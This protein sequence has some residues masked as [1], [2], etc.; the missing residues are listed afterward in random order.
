MKI[1][2]NEVMGMMEQ[3]REPKFYPN[4]QVLPVRLDSGKGTLQSID[5][6]LKRI[7]RL[8]IQMRNQSSVSDGSVLSER[9]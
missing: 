8:L 7:E 6:T 5:S 2:R 3:P 1:G 9:T 4:E